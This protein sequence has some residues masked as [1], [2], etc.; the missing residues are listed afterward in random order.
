MNHPKK[1]S[2]LNVVSKIE[3]PSSK[4]K[5]IEIEPS[6]TEQLREKFEAMDQNKNNDRSGFC[7]CLEI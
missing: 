6:I 4:Y 1:K 3:K 2:F 7:D 5:I